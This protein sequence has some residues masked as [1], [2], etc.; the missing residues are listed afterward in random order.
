MH[1]AEAGIKTAAAR[2][3]EA[4]ADVEKAEADVKA[5]KSQIEIAKADLEMAKVFVEYTKIVSP[6]TGVVISRGE[7]VHRGSFIRSA[8]DGASEPLLTVAA[9]DHMR[10]VVL[11]PDRDVPYCKAGDPATVQVDSLGGRVFNGTVSRISESEDLADRNMRVEIDLPNRDGALRDGLFGR[12]RILLEKMIKNL[13]IP[14]KCL[15]ERNGKG[16]GAVLVVKEGEVHRTTVQVGLDNGLLVEVINGL[17]E[18]DQVILQPDASI[19]DGTRVQ[20]DEVK[21]TKD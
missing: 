10:T 11:V 13:A 5:A 2:Y 8:S 18:N 19:A 4:K 17:S 9:T 3:A 21:D 7:A 14:S 6:Y 20:V 1:S 12:A 15:I 16:E